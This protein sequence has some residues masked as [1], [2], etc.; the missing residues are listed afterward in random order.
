MG[1]DMVHW[2]RWLPHPK[3]PPE[4]VPYPHRWIALGVISLGVFLVA[5]DITIVGTILPSLGQDLHAS[6]SGLQWVF[7]AFTVALAGF[8]VLGGALAE[9]YGRKGWV[10]V[11]LL[12]FASGATLSALAQDMPTV[13]LG[14]A[15]SGLG[16]AVVFPG[17]LSIISALFEVGERQKAIGIFAAISAVGMAAGPVVGGALNAWFWWGAAFLAV[18]PIALLAVVA[19]AVIVPPSYGAQMGR[20]D[21]AGAFLSALGLGGLV[22]AVIEGDNLGWGH[23]V[24]LSA[25]TAG[26]FGTLTF[27]HRELKVQSP[28]FDLRVFKDPRVVGGALAMAIVYFTFNGTQLLLP[29][30][31]V[32]VLNF[33]SLHVGLIM[34]PYGLMLLVLSPKSHAL[35]ERFGQRAMLTFSLIFMA[36]G[37]LVFALLPYWGGVANVLTGIFIFGIGFGLIVAPATAAVMIAIPK[38][39]AGDGSAVNM[40]SRQIGGAIGVA[41]AGTLAAMVYRARIDLS[42]FALSP[43]DAASVRHSLSG[44]D[45]LRDRLDPGLWAKVNAM[46]DMA[47]VDGVAAALAA[48]AFVTLGVAGV[49]FF[50]LRPRGRDATE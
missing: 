49:A 3:L 50:A 32:S 29:Q 27:I 8:V 41:I 37:L 36:L 19:M 17:C 43:K 14:R 28:L 4:G 22:F 45:A 5:L 46:A 33:S 16:A 30:Y 31:L 34:A 13:I 35:I 20:L 2:L 15:I 47:T 44:V 26:I 40:V 38:E 25:L 23:P 48:C 1:F 42:N 39:K 7:D 6:V 9:R 12:V 11:G 10:Q 21:V 18:V 24:V